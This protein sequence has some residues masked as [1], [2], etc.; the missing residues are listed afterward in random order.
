MTATAHALIGT[1]IA[2]KFGNPQLAIPIAIASHVIADYIPHWDTGTNRATKSKKRLISDSFYDVLLG[3]FL[4]FILINKFFPQTQFSYAFII[5]IFAQIFDWLLA[6][7]YF[8]GVKQFK[9]AY[10]FGKAT[11]VDLDKPWGIVTQAVVVLIV[12]AFAKIF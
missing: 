2:A 12:I 3:F 8:F 10:T 9:W 5:I 4:S 1:V 11:N 6:P 7:Y